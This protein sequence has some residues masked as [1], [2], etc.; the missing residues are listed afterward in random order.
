MSIIL[1][2]LDKK[3]IDNFRGFVVKKDLVRQLKLGAN[4]PVFVLEYLLANS[5]STLAPPP[6]RRSTALR[7]AIRAASDDKQKRS[8]ISRKRSRADRMQMKLAHSSPVS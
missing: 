2:D 6:R 4:V 8:D 3:L 1:D 5:C 7:S